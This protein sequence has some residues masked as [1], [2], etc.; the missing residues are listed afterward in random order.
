MKTLLVMATHFIDAA[1]ISEYRK[2]KNTPNVD[3]VLAINNN[4][5]KFD[6]K[7]RVEIFFLRERCPLERR[8]RLR[9]ERIDAQ[10]QPPAAKFFHPCGQFR[11]RRNV[12]QLLER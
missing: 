1:V 10:R 8:K 11:N 12:R 5:C 3:A 7:S 6:F 9:H 2:M 4:E